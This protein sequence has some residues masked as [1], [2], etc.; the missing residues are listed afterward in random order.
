MN[1]TEV[2]AALETVEQDHRLVLDK[3]QALKETVSCLLDPKGMDPRRVLD[4]L[5]EISEYCATQLEAHMEEEETTQFP[6]LERHTPEGPELVARLRS[7]HDEIRRR[8]EEFDNCLKVAAELE[9]GL[10][11]AVQ[12]DLLGYG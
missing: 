3:A 6:F 10:P 7:E 9:D 4:R 11:R 8:R 1:A 12:R 5:Q 2:M